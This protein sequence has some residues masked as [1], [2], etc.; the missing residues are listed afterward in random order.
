MTAYNRT[1]VALSD[2]IKPFEDR[3]K[4]LDQKRIIK[5]SRRTSLQLQNLVYDNII[6]SLPIRRSILKILW[7]TSII[8]SMKY[9]ANYVEYTLNKSLAIETH[10]KVN[11][12]CK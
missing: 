6:G 9:I 7:H 8:K 3:L 4:T 5:I 2:L 11:Y 10:L 12:S 1:L